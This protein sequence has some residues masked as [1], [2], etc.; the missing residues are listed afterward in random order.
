MKEQE[1]TSQEQNQELFDTIYEG[2]VF[3]VYKDEDTFYLEFP[4][5]T[6]HIP[7]HVIDGIMSDL[8]RFVVAYNRWKKESPVQVQEQ[9]PD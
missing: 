8:A 5:A 9:K 3:E 7:N 4:Y 6:I 2:S 1:G